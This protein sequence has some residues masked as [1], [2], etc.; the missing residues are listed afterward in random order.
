LERLDADQ[1]DLAIDLPSEN[2]LALDEALERL[3][4]YDKRKAAVVMLRFFSGLTIE[5]TAEVLGV[6]KPTVDRDW[7]FA[8]AVLHH[9]LAPDG[10]R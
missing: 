10:G 9:E 5:E 7:R 4:E 6:S 1:V 3:Q 8:R 2:I